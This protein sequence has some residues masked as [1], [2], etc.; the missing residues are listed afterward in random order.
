MLT[1]PLYRHRRTS[2]DAPKDKGQIEALGVTADTCNIFF[3]SKAV[4]MS[5]INAAKHKEPQ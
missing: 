1:T 2:C 3:A 4:L 5:V